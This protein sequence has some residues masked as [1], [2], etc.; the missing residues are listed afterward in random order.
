MGGAG[1]SPHTATPKD[2]IDTVSD[3]IVAVSVPD[4]CLNSHI[5]SDTTAAAAPAAAQRGR[6]LAQNPRLMPH[7]TQN[8]V[9]SSRLGPTQPFFISEFQHQA[10]IL[11]HA[12]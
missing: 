1:H 7:H 12:L 8:V 6:R 2:A 4:P 10:A 9:C 5:V 3:K 11:G